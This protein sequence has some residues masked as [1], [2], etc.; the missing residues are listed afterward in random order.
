MATKLV[1]IISLSVKSRDVGCCWFSLAVG[2]RRCSPSGGPVFAVLVLASCTVNHAGLLSIVLCGLLLSAC[3]LD[4]VKL[5][6]VGEISSMIGKGG[7]LGACS[8]AVVGGA[9]GIGCAA[10][11]RRVEE[12]MTLGS[13][14]LLSLSSGGRGP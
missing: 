13:S 9:G 8:W 2:V 5:L 6:L 4:S 12:M 1:S 3:A 7:G 10:S 14:N 11:M